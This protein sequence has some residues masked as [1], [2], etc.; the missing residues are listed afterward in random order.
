MEHAIIL[1]LLAQLPC[2]A[3]HNRR[4][5][6]YPLLH[7]RG[8]ACENREQSALAITGGAAARKSSGVAEPFARGIPRHPGAF[9]GVCSGGRVITRRRRSAQNAKSDEP[10]L[11]SAM[12]LDALGCRERVGMARLGASPGPVNRRC[13]LVGEWRALAHRLGWAGHRWSVGR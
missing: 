10:T 6:S 2:P 8:A 5:V 1:A 4:A 9:V 7:L 13:A 12:S 3:L 11:P